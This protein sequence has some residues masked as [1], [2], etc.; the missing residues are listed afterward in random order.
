MRRLLGA[1]VG[2]AIGYGAFLLVEAQEVRAL[3]IVGACLAL[4]AGLA[5][6]CRRLM[7]GVVIGILAVVVTM[8]VEWHH[9]P[10]RS[11]ES[12]AYFVT[13]I[14]SLSNKSKLTYALVGAAGLWFGMGRNRR[15]GSSD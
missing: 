5:A 10:F 12:L 9:Y 2:G 8:F 11:D 6:P 13:H 7:W 15:G 4:G 3:A 1:A 14:A